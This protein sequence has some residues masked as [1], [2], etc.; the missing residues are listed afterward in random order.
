MAQ[1]QK[2]EIEAEKELQ[3]EKKDWHKPEFQKLS[4]VTITGY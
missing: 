1:Q 2:N 3:S 4:V